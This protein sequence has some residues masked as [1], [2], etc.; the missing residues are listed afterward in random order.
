MISLVSNPTTIH[1]LPLT[2]YIDNN[3]LP[4]IQTILRDI[5]KKCKSM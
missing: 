2:I 3:I 1:K 4:K 5:D